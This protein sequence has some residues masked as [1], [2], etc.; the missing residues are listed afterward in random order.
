MPQRAPAGIFVELVPREPPLAPRAAVATGEVARALARRLL[1]E[2]D[3]ALAALRGLAGPSLLAV[4]GE[5]EQ[6]P[7][8]DGVLYL[9]SDPE[10]PRLLLPTA[11]RPSVAAGLYQSAVERHLQARAASAASGSSARPLAA[12]IAAPLAV[13]PEPRWVFSM[14]EAA[15]IQRARLAAWLGA[16][17]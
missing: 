7:W 5:A 11:L 1:E 12:A 10:A 14:A 2:D 4:L 9:G 13:L 6:L 16:A 8:V 3:E 17:R 15:S